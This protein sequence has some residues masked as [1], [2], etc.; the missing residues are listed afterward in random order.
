MQSEA[1][2]FLSEDQ[3]LLNATVK[4]IKYSNDRVWVSLA[5]GTSLSADYA[6]VTFSLGVLQHEDVLFE[7]TLPKWKS[8]AIHSMAMVSRVTRGG[9]SPSY[10]T[11]AYREHTRRYIC[12]SLRGS[13]LTPRCLAFNSHLSIL[14]RSD[15]KIP[16]SLRCMLITSGD[17]TPSGRV[18]TWMVSSQVPGSSSLPSPYASSS[19][20]KSA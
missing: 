9:S 4:T 12:S 17:G 16:P 11:I 14:G 8:E 5:D 13:G 10:L 15:V 19:S 7:P 20:A 6:L 1:A 18:L 3:I 2:E